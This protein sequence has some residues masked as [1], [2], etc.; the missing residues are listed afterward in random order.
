MLWPVNGP[1]RLQMCFMGRGRIKGV[2][3]ARV[4]E[5]KRKKGA[6]V[7][8]RVAAG[9]HLSTPWLFEPAKRPD[10]RLPGLQFP[11]LVQAPYTR[12]YIRVE[13][14]F[15]PNSEVQTMAITVN[16]NP[17]GEVQ[18]FCMSE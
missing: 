8:K 4:E 14:L 1:D 17:E 5:G 13:T 2:I 10:D 7:M 12:F 3:C 11:L 6:N 15:R 16:T 9:A 18:L